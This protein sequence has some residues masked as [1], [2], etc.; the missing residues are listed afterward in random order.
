[1]IKSL[2]AKTIRTVQA[3]IV[4]YCVSEH[5]KIP[6]HSISVPPE[7]NRAPFSRENM[8]ASLLFTGSLNGCRQLQLTFIDLS[9]LLNS[10]PMTTS[11]VFWIFPHGFGIQA[12]CWNTPRGPMA[13]AQSR[14]STSWALQTRTTLHSFGNECPGPATSI[15]RTP[16]PCST[17]MAVSLSLQ[18]GQ[19]KWR[20]RLPNELAL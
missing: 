8:P 18:N 11:L 5:S 16:E 10:P 7:D 14:E 2:P 9:S 17:F 12:I 4:H 19:G 1:M 20:A 6:C 13:I 3:A 15:V